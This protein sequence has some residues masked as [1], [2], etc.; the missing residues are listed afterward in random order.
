MG[1][2][3]STIEIL[4]KARGLITDRYN[5]TRGSYAR[6]DTGEV[7]NVDDPK[8]VCWCTLGA[9][10]KVS[11][12]DLK[13]EHRATLAIQNFLDGTYGFS[14]VARFNDNHSHEEV[15]SVFDMTI[16]G[17]KGDVDE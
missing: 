17:L 15:L 5:W 9:I 10:S 16:L 4:E 14:H 13:K 2:D 1:T 6:D 3:E 8:S 12:R 7:C 11:E